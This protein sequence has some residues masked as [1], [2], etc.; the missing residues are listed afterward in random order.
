[1]QVYSLADGIRTWM[2]SSTDEEFCWSSSP[3]SNKE[4]LLFT[5]YQLEMKQ[6]YL[7]G[8]MNVPDDKEDAH[9]EVTMETLGK[10][11]TLT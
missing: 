3:D 10:D 8:K 6:R 7:V 11:S 4:V 1:M 9:Q 2:V 5:H